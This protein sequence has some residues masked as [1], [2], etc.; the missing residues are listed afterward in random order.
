MIKEIDHGGNLMEVAKIMGLKD[1]LFI[2]GA[3]KGEQRKEVKRALQSKEV[4][5]VIVTVIWREGVNIPSLDCVVNAMGGKSEIATLQAIGR[6]LRTYKEKKEVEIVDFV[7]CHKYL[8]QHFT[9]RLSIY[10]ENNWL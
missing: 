7:D 10:L 3:T 6:G 5:A 2:Q 9:M 4:K 1:I 8:S